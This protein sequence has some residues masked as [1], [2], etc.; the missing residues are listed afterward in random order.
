M[1]VTLQD[2]KPVPKVIDFGVAKAI[3]RRLTEKTLFTQLGVIVGTP[4]Y[5]SPEQARL[6]GLDVDTRSDIYSLGVLL[7][8]L[9]TGTTPLERERL[10]EAAFT[11]VLRRI[12]EEEP[13]RPSTRLGPTQETASIAA[14]RG[15]EPARLVRQMRGDLDWIVMKALE[16]EPARRYETA[17]GLARDIR[18][19]LEGDPVEAGPPSAA[20]RLRKFARK[21]RAALATAS[22]FAAVLLAAT[23]IST[24]QAVRATRAEGL[25]K[26]NLA[27]ARDEEARAIRAEGLAKE[28]LARAREGEANAKRSAA[29]WGTV[30]EFLRDKILAAARPAGQEGG[31][32]RNVTLREAIDKAEATIIGSFAD[33]PKVE[34]VIRDAM[35]LSYHHLGEPALAIRQYERAGALRGRARARP[36]RHPGQHQQR[37]PR[38]SDRRPASG[39]DPAL[40]GDIPAH[41]AQAGARRPQDA[42]HPE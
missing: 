24:W 35:G 3:D 22:A 19:H 34:A 32:G 4:E 14:Q 33:Q 8:E 11:E 13:P 15:T 25:A 6:S 20:Y 16:K 30:L 26:E 7:Y 23:A 40:R 9:L 37:R 27:R 2:G 10:R 31:L 36:S 38:L 42:H 18:R 12:R 39:C 28:N 1:L 41:A 17:E 29:E 5:M 21:H